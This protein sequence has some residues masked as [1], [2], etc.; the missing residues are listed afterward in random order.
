MR[1]RFR[2]YGEPISSSAGSLPLSEDLGDLAQ[3]RINTGDHDQTYPTCRVCLV[4]IS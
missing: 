4:L 2:R 1:L 3:M